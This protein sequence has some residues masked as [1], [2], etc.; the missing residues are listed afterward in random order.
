MQ[1]A[2]A[3]H[4]HGG[5]GSLVQEV[6]G[7]VDTWKGR[8]TDVAS[9]CLEGLGHVWRGRILK[10]GKK[11]GSGVCLAKQCFGSAWL[12]YGSG[13]G[14]LH[15]DPDPDVDPDPDKI[16]NRF[17]VTSLNMIKRCYVSIV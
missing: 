7:A 6:I 8:V 9:V 12:H 4:G 11:I 10:M 2:V 14:T 16:Q 5:K 3:L 13:S 1:G 15:L 17:P